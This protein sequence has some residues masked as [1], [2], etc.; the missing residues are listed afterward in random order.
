MLF[1]KRSRPPVRRTTSR[2]ALL[3]DVIESPP[4]SDD[5][6][7]EGGE[8]GQSVILTENSF[9]NELICRDDHQ[10]YLD[11]MVLS[12]RY[13]HRKNC[14]GSVETAHFLTSCGLCQRR[15]TPAKDIYMY[16][17]DTAFCSLECREEQIK[18]D[19]TKERSDVNIMHDNKE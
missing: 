4:M 2:T 6:P 11:S 18:Q 10:R 14:D 16:R 1:G 5:G 15:L 8:G 13:H 12:P 17:G 7:E 9:G 3:D 19:E